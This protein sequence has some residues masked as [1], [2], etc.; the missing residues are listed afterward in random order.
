VNEID[1]EIIIVTFFTI[2]V[3]NN[4]TW[5]RCTI[6][7]LDHD[8][9]VKTQ[10][11]EPTQVSGHSLKFHFCMFERSQKKH[12]SLDCHHFLG[13]FFVHCKFYMLKI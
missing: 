2:E 13:I 6:G 10:S 3:N 5:N 8:K 4:K 7:C 12:N 1:Q 9:W 11:K